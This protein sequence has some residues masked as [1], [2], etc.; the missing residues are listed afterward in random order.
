M[1]K[2]SE[3]KSAKIRRKLKVRNKIKGTLQRPRLSVFRSNRSIYA[4]LIDDQK[5]VTLTAA[6][7]KMLAGKIETKIKTSQ[8]KEKKPSE[9]KI[10][11]PKTKLEKAYLVG[12]ILAEQALKKGIKKAVFD[13]GSYRY[14]GRVKK[15]AEGAR[16]AGLNF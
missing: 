11:K 6:S 10:I 14:H 1:N 9:T 15:L 5:G 3:F 16:E 7:E 12:Q 4:Q 2:A 8:K 13:R